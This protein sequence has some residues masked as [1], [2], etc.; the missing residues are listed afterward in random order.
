MYFLLAKQDCLLA[1]SSCFASLVQARWRRGE[2]DPSQQHPDIE[3]KPLGRGRCLRSDALGMHR[4]VHLS[5]MTPGVNRHVHRAPTVSSTLGTVPPQDK[6]LWEQFP[7]PS[8][9]HF[10][11]NWLAVQQK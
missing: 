10:S 7:S 9:L 3:R 11:S 2:E 1:F 4:Y 8:K 5:G 6:G